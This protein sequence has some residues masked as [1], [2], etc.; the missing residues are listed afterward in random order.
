M[1]AAFLTLTLIFFLFKFK[2][3]SN[4]SK[5]N[6][7]NLSSISI[8]LFY[9]FALVLAQWY[10]NNDFIIEKC[11]E[12]KSGSVFIATLVPNILIFSLTMVLLLI[13]PGWKG[14]FSNTLGYMF[15]KLLNIKGSFDELLIKGETSDSLM[16]RIIEDKSLIINEIS[17]VNFDIFLRNMDS[18][19]LLSENYDVLLKAINRVDDDDNEIPAVGTPEQK[20]KGEALTNLW[21]AVALKDLIGEI[22]WYFLAGTL[23]MSIIQSNITSMECVRNVMVAEE[24][25]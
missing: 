24:N 4:F 2:T 6:D 7:V 20:A 14:P 10:E 19:G 22:T 11:G 3:V 23:V 15:A 8:F 5:R 18:Y 9:F 13:F 16:K 12:E 25:S 1:F 21:R 17:T